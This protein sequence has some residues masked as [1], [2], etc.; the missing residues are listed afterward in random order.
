MLNYIT[1]LL[2]F[3][4]LAFAVIVLFKNVILYLRQSN[5]LPEKES[6]FINKFISE[7]ELKLDKAFEVILQ[8]VTFQ[9]GRLSQLKTHTMNLA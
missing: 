5:D 8:K 7:G 9:M 1:I 4:L 6:E 2:V 3:I